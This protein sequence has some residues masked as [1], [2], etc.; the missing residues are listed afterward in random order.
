MGK[1]WDYVAD[2]QF[3]NMPKSFRED[4][5]QLREIAK[6]NEQDSSM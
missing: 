2:K 6:N 3:R 5:A 1:K 4:W